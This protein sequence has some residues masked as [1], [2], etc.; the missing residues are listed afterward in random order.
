[1][2]REKT[3]TINEIL[4]TVENE[5]S[6]KEVAETID[7]GLKSFGCSSNNWRNFE[8]YEASIKLM[9]ILLEAKATEYIIAIA[10]KADEAELSDVKIIVQKEKETSIWT[11]KW[12]QIEF[13]V[14]LSVSDKRLKQLQKSL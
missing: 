9:K 3:K 4:E 8:V 1:M 12:N 13:M 2:A 10:D 6:R 7:R 11:M 5:K 14:V